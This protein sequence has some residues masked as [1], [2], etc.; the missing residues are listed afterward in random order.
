MK[1]K[2]RK[3]VSKLTLKKNKAVQS[4]APKFRVGFGTD[5]HPFTLGRALVLGGVQIPHSQGL[6]GNSDADVLI[7]AIMDALLGAAGLGDIGIHFPNTDSQYR[8]ISSLILL[9]RVK[10]LTED[11]GFSVENIDATLVME[12]PKIVSFL[13]QMQ[14]NI[15]RVLKI[16]LEQVNI[17]ATRAERLGFIG[18]AEG[19]M[20]QAVC[21]LTFKS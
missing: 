19:A 4:S 12:T 17:K 2:K 7:H 18:R 20:S 15:A 5:I 16:K 21:L 6:E 13:P 10:S 3:S 8:G 9:E 1:Q 14:K 11:K